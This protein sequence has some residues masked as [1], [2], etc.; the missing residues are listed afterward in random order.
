MKKLSTREIQLEEKKIL[1][2]VVKFLDD[3][4]LKCFLAGGTML[5]AIRHHGFIPWDD[6]IDILMTRPDYD[7]LQEIIKRGNQIPNSD[8]YFHSIG[9]HNSTFPFTKVYKRSI[10]VYDRKYDDK[11]EKYL[12]IDIFPIDGLPKNDAECYK[13]YKRKK[14]YERLMKYRKINNEYLLQH[15]GIL[16]RYI[17][18]MIKNILKLFS[19]EYFAKKIISLTKKYPYNQSDYVGCLVWGYGPQERMTKEDAEDY[20]EVTFEGSKYLGFK[21]FDQ[22]LSNLYG[23]YM[24][25]PPEEKR[26]THNIDVWRIENEEIKK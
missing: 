25:L 22:Y 19:D 24:K 14:R 11:Y 12:W 15:N 10:E 8:L 4:H 23:D 26:V 2:L 13:L 18:L 1:D 20:I 16:K 21:N 5:G 9:L 3:H 7:K 6:D 17:R